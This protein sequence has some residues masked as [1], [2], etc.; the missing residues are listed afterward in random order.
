MS[1]DQE[2]IQTG[3]HSA[4]DNSSS[5]QSHLESD[6]ALADDRVGGD[7]LGELDLL[8]RQQASSYKRLLLRRVSQPVPWCQQSPGA[9]GMEV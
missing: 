4:N 2:V 8:R 5:P 9:A 6:Q 3:T 1:G 7:V